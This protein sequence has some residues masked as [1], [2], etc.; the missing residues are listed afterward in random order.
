MS[1][2]LVSMQIFSQNPE[3]PDLIPINNGP[4]YNGNGSFSNACTTPNFTYSVTGDF[5]DTDDTS[6][7]GK[8]ELF[9][10]PAAWEA[11]FGTFV[12]LAVENIMVEVDNATGVG[13]PI[14]KT[15][16]TTI[17]FNSPVPANTL[18]FI[19]SD[20]EQDQVTVKALDANNMPVPISDIN[21][22]YQASFD[23]NTSDNTV[24]CP[25]GQSGAEA[26]PV[27]DTTTGTL[28]G[29]YNNS[30]GV[31]QTVYQ[32]DLCDNEAGSA[33]FFVDTEIQ[34]L[35]FESQA[36]GVSPDDPSQHFV[37]AAK[38]PCEEVAGVVFL[39]ADNDGCD[40]GNVG[41]AN[42][43][44]NLIDCSGATIAT[45]TTAAD[46][47]YAFGLNSN[48]PNAQICLDPAETYRVEISNLPA[49]HFYTTG[50]GIGCPAQDDD[51]PNNDGESVCYNPSD[52][53]PT[54]GIEDQH[55]D[56]G[57]VP[58][59]EI[60]G[61]VFIDADNDGCDPGAVGVANVTVELFQC[62]GAIG[63]I[64][65]TTTGADGSYEFG[66]DA[67]DPNANECLDPAKTYR[68]KI[69]NIPS[70][71]IF[72]TGPGVNCATQEDDSPLNN[73]LSL[74]Y[75]PIDTDAA[76]G[77][78]DQHV[79]FGL[80][81]CQEMAGV[82]FVDADNDGCDPG[83]SGVPG[84]TVELFECGIA[85][86]VATT[87]TGADGSY[88]IGL[89]SPDP[90]AQVCLDP[91]KTNIPNDHIFST[92]AGA[93]C[94]GAEDDSPANDG[95]SNCYNPSDTDPADGMEEVLVYL[96]SLLNSLS[97]V[98]RPQ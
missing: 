96:V 78:E 12:P 80:V 11:M 43:N 37:L 7:P 30:G 29:Q 63:P 32:T 58:C 35:I 21:S 28:V 42:V 92:G 45:T 44:L 49:D 89:S 46:G 39:D 13:T 38:C 79:D 19:I 82:V 23:G 75:N 61:V 51:S 72:S 83:G 27:W 66:P 69:S 8:P 74:C 24:E 65:S 73:G 97:V 22:W 77:M 2:V 41:I 53:D 81:P 57:L 17:T 59:Q 15:V 60:A 20:V 34:T 86:P 71:H 48:D 4:T 67:A 9:D 18:G 62:G 95:V 94:P 25:A 5:K 40:P 26:P 47:S 84:V 1:Y 54:D 3:Y 14:N 31:K 6:I 70:D 36:L 93:G 64:A 55:I 76:D 98:L 33:Y 56:F 91:A 88:V 52:D 16:V 50:A 10:V 68:V 87:T 85:A 90:N